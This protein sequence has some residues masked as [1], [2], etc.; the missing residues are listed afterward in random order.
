MPLQAC[1]VSGRRRGAGGRT[2]GGAGRRA[3]IRREGPATR[4][5]RCPGHALATDCFRAPGQPPETLCAGRTHGKGMRWAC[6]DRRH[7]PKPPPLARRQPDLLTQLLCRG[8]GTRDRRLQAAAT[9]RPSCAGGAS[10]EAPR[11]GSWKH[12]IR[13]R[14]AATSLHAAERQG[15]SRHTGLPRLQEQRLPAGGRPVHVDLGTGAT[16]AQ[17]L[18]RGGPARHSPSPAGSQVNHCVPAWVVR[19]LDHEHLQGWGRGN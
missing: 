7:E 6:L 17:C 10:R 15:K 16:A 8:W 19:A 12:D 9:F 2:C 4:E 11:T 14:G 18:G 1:S 5:I 13:P 3:R